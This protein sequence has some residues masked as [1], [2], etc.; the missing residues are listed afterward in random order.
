MI[1]ICDYDPVGLGKYRYTLK[2]SYRE[3]ENI[4]HEDG[5]HTVYLSTKGQNAEE[6]PEELSNF[7]NWV[8]AATANDPETEEAEQKDE[9]VRYCQRKVKQI[10]LDREMRGRYM[11]FEEMMKDEYKEGKEAGIKEGITKSKIAD[12]LS[13]LNEK[14]NVSPE[15][16]TK[17]KN[18]K[19]EQKLSELVKCAVLAESIEEFEEQLEKMSN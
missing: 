1:F 2:K 17:I 10:K 7:L 13:F 6:V 4:M 9:F 14:G 12:I 11:L 3:A 8:G 5:S 16:K 15:L 18:L 19:D